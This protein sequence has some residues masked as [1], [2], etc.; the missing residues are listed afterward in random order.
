M[1]P[2]AQKGRGGNKILSRQ[3]QYNKITARSVEI[4]ETLFG[5]LKSRNEAIRLGA[6]RTL[7]DKILPDLKAQEFKETA[8]P[9]IINVMTFGESDP[10]HK[11]LEAHPEY[12]SR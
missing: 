8:E 7:L 3:A 12:L 10:L 4:L 9:P 5:L 1:E 2:Q 11:Y 6:A